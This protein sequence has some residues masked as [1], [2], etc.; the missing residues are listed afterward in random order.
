MHGAAGRHPLVL[1]AVGGEVADGAVGVGADAELVSLAELLYGPI[2]AVSTSAAAVIS[3]KL[4]F[5]ARGHATP[6]P[7]EP[8]TVALSSKAFI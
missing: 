2:A 5:C 7:L 4:A 6:Y 3:L 1:A 8:V